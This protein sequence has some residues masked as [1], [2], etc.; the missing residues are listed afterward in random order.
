MRDGEGTLMFRGL[1][2]S[3]DGKRVLDTTRTGSF[4][5]DEAARLGD[6]AGRELKLQAGPDFFL[7]F[8]N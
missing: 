2:A 5:T 7:N 6:D 4:S 8:G 1:V 3:P